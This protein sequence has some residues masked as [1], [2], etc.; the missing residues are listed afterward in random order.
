MRARAPKTK[1]PHA[2]ALSALGASKGGKARAA[3]LSAKE[4]SDQGRQAVEARWR[5]ARA[6]TAKA[7]RK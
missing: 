7:K 4:L 6:N 2:V 1:N 5:K 3:K